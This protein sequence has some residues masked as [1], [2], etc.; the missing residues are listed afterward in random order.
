MGWVVGAAFLCLVGLVIARAAML[1]RRGIQ[2]MVFGETDKSDFA[3]PPL[4]LI[5]AY[6][7]LAPGFG[8]PMWAP[9][10]AGWWTSDIPGWIGAVLCW[11]AVAGLAWALASFGESFRV[12]ID[13][14]EPGGLITTGAFAHSRNPVYTC[15]VAFLAGLFLA[16]HNA[17]TAVVLVAVAAVMH[18]QVLR[19]EKFLRAHYGDEF[20]AY[21]ATVRRYL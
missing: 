3:L 12:G 17:V 8:W 5:V 10:V 14:R 2:A 7:V 15:F 13:E 20:A 11:L 19:E 4:V 16:Q 21:A 18:R 9:V 6:C 1:R